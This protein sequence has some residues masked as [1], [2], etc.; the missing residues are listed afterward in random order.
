MSDFSDFFP[1]AGGGGGGIPKYQEFTS[2][3]T[4][5][6]TQ[7]LIDAGGRIGLIVVGA[8]GGGSNVNYDSFGGVGGEV[9]IEYSTLTST[10]AI[11]VT[12]GAGGTAGTNG[13]DGT[14]TTF[15][16]SSAGSTDVVSAGGM[17]AKDGNQAGYPQI[18]TTGAGFPG[19]LN[20]S[21]PSSAGS[22]IMGYGVG[23][24]GKRAT[25]SGISNSYGSGGGNGTAGGSGFVRVTWFE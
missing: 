16:A 24:G 2:S 6:P 4:F 9:K 22:G 19:M 23:G 15:A 17:G 7:A 5:T 3:A 13:T 12:I 11:T 14:S 18:T 21:G 8:G 10:N 1:A 20:V 25:G